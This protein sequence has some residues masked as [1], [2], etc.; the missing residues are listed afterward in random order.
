MIGAFKWEGRRERCQL[1]LRFVF[2]FFHFKNPTFRF[3]ISCS[4]IFTFLYFIVLRGYIEAIQ[5]IEQ[6]LQSE[7]GTVKFDDIVV[8]CGRFCSMPSLILRVFTPNLFKRNGKLV[9]IYSINIRE[10]IM[11]HQLFCTFVK[12]VKVHQCYDHWTPSV[13]ALVGW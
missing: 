6:Q 5:E 10:L 2:F 3:Q 7:T 13:G 4:N 8:A 1:C 11:N 9:H 12:S